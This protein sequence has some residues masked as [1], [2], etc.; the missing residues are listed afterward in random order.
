MRYKVNKMSN[1]I[2]LHAYARTDKN[3]KMHYF[4]RSSDVDCIINLRDYVFFIFPYTKD[5]KAKARIFLC[6]ADHL[7]DEAG[8]PDD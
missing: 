3:G 7:N 8:N 4:V 1:R 6:P 2:Q 5:A